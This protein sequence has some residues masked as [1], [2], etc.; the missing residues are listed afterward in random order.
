[1]R[2]ED[3][4]R[5]QI[6]LAVPPPNG[7]SGVMRAQALLEGPSGVM[8]APVYEGGAA[9]KPAAQEGTAAMFR[10]PVSS[11]AVSK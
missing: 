11:F 3:Y 4:S 5:R 1:M 10:S 7:P 8:R 2:A 9:P 6:D